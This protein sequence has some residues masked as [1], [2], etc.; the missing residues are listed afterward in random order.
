MNALDLGMDELWLLQVVP[1]KVGANYVKFH[2]TFK[3]PP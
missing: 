1:L 2:K 3:N